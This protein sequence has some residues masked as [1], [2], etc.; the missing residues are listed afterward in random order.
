MNKEDNTFNAEMEQFAKLAQTLG[1]TLEKVISRG[2]ERNLLG[3]KS[4]YVLFS[5]RLDSRTYFVQDTRYGNGLEGG[6]FR[7]T[8]E[9]QYESAR[10]IFKHLN[11]PL[12]EIAEEVLQT[13]MTQEAYVHQ[14]SGE[15][16]LE[17]VQEGKS[18]VY[19]TRQIQDIPVWSSN[20]T[21]G[22]MKEKQIGFMQLHWPEIPRHVI[23][24]AHKLAQKIEAGWRPDEQKG[25]II[26]SVEAGIIH[27]P[28][29]GFVMDILPVIRV[30]SASVDKNFSRK[31]VLYLDRH[32]I[33][34]P[35]P[36]HAIMPFEPKQQERTLAKRGGISLRN[37]VIVAVIVIAAII[38]SIYY[39]LFG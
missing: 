1:L 13:E 2:S 29:I 7:G 31:Q 8:K 30:V 25:A 37:L 19:F 11:I 32:G 15:V 33:D 14:E 3:I 10:F 36:R 17:E 12:N 38:I 23:E 39:V 26:E 20:L 9:E 4:E 21:L 6:I 16:K 18:F 24:E 28:A 34:V 5:R 27:S 35:L 22:L